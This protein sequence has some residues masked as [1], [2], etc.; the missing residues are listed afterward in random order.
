M[1]DRKIGDQNKTEDG[2]AGPEVENVAP[3][4]IFK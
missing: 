4:S 2:N 3:N 1:E